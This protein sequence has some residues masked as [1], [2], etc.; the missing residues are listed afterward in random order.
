[1]YPDAGILA[2]MGVELIQGPV[3][4]P[5]YAQKQMKPTPDRLFPGLTVY[6][7]VD[8]DPELQELMCLLL[9]ITDG[10]AFRR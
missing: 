9:Q 2:A 10:R 3:L 6:Q 5:L 1:M 8:V 4:L 7:V